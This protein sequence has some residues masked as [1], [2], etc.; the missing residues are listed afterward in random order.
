MLMLS[1]SRFLIA[2]QDS[3]DSLRQILADLDTKDTTYVN[4]ANDIAFR[5]SM[6]D[7]QQSIY[8][9]NLALSVSKDLNYELGII[10]AMTMKGNSFLIIGMPDQALSYYLE[11]FDFK[12]E[13]YPVEYIRLNNNIGEVYRRKSVYDSSLKYFNKALLLAKESVKSFPR[14]II[15]SNIGEVSLMQNNVDSAQNYFQQCLDYAIETDDYRGV[16]YGYYGLA[17]CAFL[18]GKTDEAIELMKRSI[19]VRIEKAN[20]RRGTVQSY[21]KIGNYFDAMGPTRADST[22][23]YWS[24][25]E[26]A[27]KEIEANDLLTEVYNQL[28]AFYFQKN[29]IKNAAV[30]LEKHKKLG[31]SIRNAEFISS[32]GKIKSALN[33]EILNAENELLKQQTI[34][35]EA[36]EDARLIV[37]S[38]AFLI[39]FALIIASYQSQMRQKAAREAENESKFTETLLTLSRILNKTDF[40]LDSFIQQLLEISRK[41]IASDRATYWTMDSENDI[42][43]LKSKA[44]K[45]SNPEVPLITFRKSQIA[46]IFSDFMSK[47]TFAISQ[48]SKDERVTEVFE[49]Y[50]RPAGIETILNAPII[51][52]DSFKGFISFTMT[53]L[54]LRDWNLSEQRYAA[55]LADLMVS[56]LSKHREIMLEKE[57]GELIQKLRS[58]NKN[59]QEFNSVVS[60]NLRE[61][62][63]QIIGLSDILKSEGA[64]SNGHSK[65]IITRLADSSNKVDK[66]IKEL[67]IILSESDPNPSDF[68][69]VSLQKLLK[70]VL[71][72]LKN[73]IK[74]HNV[75][76]EQNLEVEKVKSY[77]PYLSDIIYHLISNAIKF[78]LPEKRLHINVRSYEDDLKQFI[79]ISDNGRGMDLERF[80]D[81]IFKMYQRYH[82]DVEGRGIGLFIVRNRVGV[83][84]G[85]I[86]VESKVDE[87]TTF[88]I[89]LPKYG[90]SLN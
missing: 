90:S 83:L 43:S 15:Y 53:N 33:S 79:Q 1:G 45:R 38:L 72:L 70:D 7:Q 74:D 19:N 20:H 3:L 80:G 6:S 62:L 75:T 54:K 9:I 27:A 30:Y 52:N 11:V 41:T 49:K 68:K 44:E 25:T 51:V 66:V 5:L 29:D 65:E 13:K 61:P 37:I 14:A 50:F 82:L 60:H 8:Y 26:K 55:S 17:E 87:G 40:D 78:S 24:I 42:L 84:N 16:G 86:K 71:D 10:R 39:I 57:K 2:Q 58:R 46:G 23:H 73:D 89:E 28:Y 59:L 4:V 76:I 88:T 36:E 63:T 47:R 34:Q 67:S 12:Q 18:S 22:L 69:Q 56:A 77:K 85:S 32:V 35:R 48:L 21:L 31:D 64:E 81:K